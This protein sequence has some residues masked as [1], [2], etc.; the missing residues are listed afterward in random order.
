MLDRHPGTPRVN[1][2]YNNKKH[3]ETANTLYSQEFFMDKIPG[4]FSVAAKLS[5]KGD[6]PYL[7]EP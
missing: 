6:Q 4:E 1:I 3:A 7:K 5:P 2:F